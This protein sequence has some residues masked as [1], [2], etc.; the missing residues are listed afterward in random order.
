MEPS[1]P[2]RAFQFGANAAGDLEAKCRTCGN[3]ANIEYIEF[4]PTS[5][6]RIECGACKLSVIAEVKARYQVA[7]VSRPQMNL[8]ARLLSFLHIR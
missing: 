5:K 4:P 6:M 7:T 2:S 3:E 8:K 1:A